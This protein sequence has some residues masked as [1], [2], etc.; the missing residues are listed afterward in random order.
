MRVYK[1]YIP[2]EQDVSSELN[3]RYQEV[4]LLKAENQIL[5]LRYSDDQPRDDHGRWTD[6]GGSGDHPETESGISGKHDAKTAENTVDLEY[7]KSE[8]YKAKFK[9]ITGSEKADQQLYSQAKAILTHRNGTYKEDMVLIDSVTGEIAG[10][11]SNSKPDNSVE[12]NSSLEKAISGSS[13][14]SLISLH[15]HGTNNPPTG[16]DLVS[17]GANKYK[18][19]VVVT[20]NGRVFTYKVGNSPFL[21]K[22]FDDT[23]DKFRSEGY[24]ED[25]A[26]AKALDQF[27]LSH[28]IEWSER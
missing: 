19:G 5:H 15:N 9:G 24:N 8:E 26:M 22:T 23:V 13:P 27:R 3:N 4:L 28:G 7:L 6:G 12:Y 21:A 25:E 17:N 2:K 1:R 18:L 14:Y 10:R 16:S 11:Q 20:H